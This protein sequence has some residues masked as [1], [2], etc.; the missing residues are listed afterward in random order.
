MGVLDG[1]LGAGGDLESDGRTVGC[2]S[3]CDRHFNLFAFLAILAVT[4]ILIIG[5]K[6]SANFNTGDRICEA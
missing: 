2:A 4:T 6:E 3:A 1:P 5:I